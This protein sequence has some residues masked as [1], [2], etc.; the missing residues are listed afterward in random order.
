MNLLLFPSSAQNAKGCRMNLRC[1][2]RGFTLIE[3]LVVIAIIAVLI[4]LLLPAVQAAREAARRAQCVNNLKQLGLAAHNYLSVNSTFPPQVQNGASDVW[5][6]AGLGGPYWDPW[7]LDWT[8]SLLPQFEQQ[9]LYNALNFGFSSGFN[10]GDT[11]NT[12]VL[13][14]QVSSMLCPSE[15][16]KSTTIGPGTRKNYMANVGGPA[17]I[18]AWNGMFVALKDTP[19]QGGMLASYCGVYV[20][21]NSGSTFGT[22]SITDG[23]SNT[24]LFS[25]SLIGSGPSAGPGVTIS[26]AKRKTTYLFRVNSPSPNVDIPNGGAQ[27]L[28][29]AQACLALPGNTVAFGTLSPPNGNV[30]IAGNPGSCMMWDAYNHWMPPNSQGCDN[31]ADGNTGGYAALTDAFP[32]SSNHPGGINVAMADGSVKFIK[33]TINLQAWWGLGSRNGG[34][35]ISADSY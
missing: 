31:T 24:A 5:A 1:N 32:P 13:A 21:S 23:S 26:T 28:A 29:F 10:G 14:T 2:R 30:W 9:T 19:A 18:S 27:A 4:A 11:Q 15:D 34:E 7:P 35:V 6:A 33:N 16:K 12:T 25:E 8:A 3:L 17:P 22:E 20:N